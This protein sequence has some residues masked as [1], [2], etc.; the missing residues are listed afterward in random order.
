MRF[1]R[2]GSSAENWRTRWL[3]GPQADPYT[4]AMSLRWPRIAY[5]TTLAAVILLL[6]STAAVLWHHHDNLQG[7]V[8]QV[9]QLG[10]LPILKARFPTLVPA[11]AVLAWHSSAEELITDLDPW[12]HQEPSRAPPAA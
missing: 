1:G 8:C 2:S 12:S 4:L 3:D 11:L 5:V 9:C 7:R 6:A 10:H